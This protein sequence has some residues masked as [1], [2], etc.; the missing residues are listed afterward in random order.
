M[1]YTGVLQA[2]AL[3][4]KTGRVIKALPATMICVKT[5]DYLLI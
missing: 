5:H 4:K 2:G 1:I 3:S